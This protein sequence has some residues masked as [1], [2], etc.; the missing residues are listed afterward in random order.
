[1]TEL[2]SYTLLPAVKLMTQGR[3]TWNFESLYEDGVDA[4][5]KAHLSNGRVL[6]SSKTGRG[7]K[8]EGQLVIAGTKGYI[9]VPAPWW[10]TSS[11]EIRHEDPSQIDRISMEYVGDGLRYEISEF[12]GRIQGY[13]HTDLQLTQDESVLLARIMEDFLRNREGVRT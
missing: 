8:S 11:F 2:G 7:V 4:Y 12:V 3:L 10:K 13:S 9:L 1:F 5:T 6:S